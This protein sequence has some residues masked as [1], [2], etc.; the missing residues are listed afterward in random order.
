MIVLIGERVVVEPFA[1]GDL[2]A[3]VA[4]RNDP[5]IARYQGWALPFTDEQAARLIAKGSERAAFEPGWW[6]QLAIRRRADAA[7]L[8]DVYVHRLAPS[9]HTAELGITIAIE[10]QRH[11]YAAEAVELVL[12]AM[13]GPVVRKVIAYVDVRNSASIAL[14]DRLGFRREGVLADSFALDDGTFADEVLFGL[15]APARPGPSPALTDRVPG[16]PTGDDDLTE[17]DL[18]TLPP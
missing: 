8:G 1:V 6:A 15:T 14:F 4:Y 10:F 18:D 12:D 13:L 11:G 2:A 3:L 5:Q 17:D 16:D 7:L 9:P